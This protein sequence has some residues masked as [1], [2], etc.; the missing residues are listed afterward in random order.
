VA[1]RLS[2][3]LT[4]STRTI[5][6]TV[7]GT[8]VAMSALAAGASAYKHELW[9]L[10]AVV[11]VGSIVF[12]IAHVYAHSLAETIT[13]GRRMS[14][15]EFASVAR[16]EVSI[17]FAAVLPACALALGAANAI[18]DRAAIW[19]ALGAGTATLAVQ[20]VRY[21]RVERLGP[22]ASFFAVATN[23]SLG[24]VIIALKVLVSH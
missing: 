19:L 11:A 14:A 3:V 13:L 1:G 17:V 12:W 5:A 23:V 20:G 7:Y 22:V 6:G 4:G 21:A 16:R 18:G 9:R 24:G 8:I 15:A 10:T 2:R